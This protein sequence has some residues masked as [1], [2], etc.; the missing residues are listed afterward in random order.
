[1]L[2]SGTT[3]CCDCMLS[4]FNQ[5]P[6]FLFLSLSIYLS[7]SLS[8]SLSLLWLRSVSSED[9]LSRMSSKGGPL[10]PNE[11]WVSIITYINKNTSYHTF[12]NIYGLIFSKFFLVFLWSYSLQNISFSSLFNSKIL[13]TKMNMKKFRYLNKKIEVEYLVLF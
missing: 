7:L 12:W 13:V 10:S 8:L 6:F 3:H 5:F 2:V 9:Q 11:L 4:F 1:M